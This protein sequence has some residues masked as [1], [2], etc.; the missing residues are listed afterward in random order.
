M[1]GS[2]FTK[3]DLH[4]CVKFDKACSEIV[5]SLSTQSRILSWTHYRTLQNVEDDKAR[6]WNKQET[7]SQNWS[8][9]T[10]KRSIETLHYER[11]LMSRIREP[12]EEI[13]GV[14]AETCR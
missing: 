1:R 8:V 13:Q 7:I 10:P 5:Y 11:L 12:E 14:P 3:R 4:W 6:R 9:R 2:G